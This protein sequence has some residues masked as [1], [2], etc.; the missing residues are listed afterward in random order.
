MRNFWR[1]AILII[2]LT[3]L[4]PAA[5]AQSPDPSTALHALINQARLDEGLVP[6]K[7]FP[8]LS[9]AAQRHADDLA[10]NGFADPDDA[11]L[12]SDGTYEQE[13]IAEAGY[14]AW[15]RDSG[16]P[17]V[18][19][20][21]WVGYGSPENALAF[22]LEES[23]ENILNLNYREIGIGIATDADGVNYYVITFGAR[24][25]AL[26]IFINDEAFNT[27]DPQVAIRLSNEEARPEG[28]GNAFMGRAIEI[29]ISNE[30]TFEDL[31]WQ[32]W[33]PLVPWTIPDTLG[34]HTIYV[35]FRDAAGRTARSADSIFFGEADQ[36]P[37]TIPPN[38]TPSPSPGGG[39]EANG[40]AV[41]GGTPAPGATPSPA[42]ISEAVAITP[43]PTWTPLPT[44]AGPESS[45]GQE[46]VEAPVALLLSL[47]GLAL[48]LGLYLILRRRSAP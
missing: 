9:N 14:E 18:D 35:Q 31:P 29:R 21:V 10:A 12:G 3:L 30:P 22:F 39:A 19:E 32:N 45:T 16:Q 8:P 2:F 48:L 40:T 44:P 43:F 4:V 26:P 11:H 41:P 42:E 34:E 23:N 20:N 1:I 7:L 17:I 25:N 15:T 46:R 36:I 6:Y 47:Q 27:T 13:R 5:G 33:E 38:L 24:P 37:P 28:K